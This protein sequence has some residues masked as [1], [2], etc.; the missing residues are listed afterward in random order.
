M[1]RYV[2]ISNT[3]NRYTLIYSHYQEASDLNWAESDGVKATKSGW[4]VAAKKVVGGS[5]KLRSS[6][7]WYAADFLLLKGHIKQGIGLTDQ[8]VQLQIQT[9]VHVCT[10]LAIAMV[11]PILGR[12]F[13]YLLSDILSRKR[14]VNIR[15]IHTSSGVDK[16]YCSGEKEK[17]HII[18]RSLL[19]PQKME[20]KIR[21]QFF[22]PKY[23][24]N[25]CNINFWI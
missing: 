23:T 6:I 5:L 7:C 1:H 11:E 20:K 2:C 3:V 15:M 24:K 13:F 4:W 21:L 12:L 18:V 10:L 17:W 16:T 9:R 25:I 14:S 8:L 22:S 19:L